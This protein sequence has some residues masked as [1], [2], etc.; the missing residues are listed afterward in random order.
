MTRHDV[1]S[2]VHEIFFGATDSS[3]VSGLLDKLEEALPHSDISDLI[4]HDFR[5]L[6]PEQVVDE[7][8]KRQAEHAA[9]SGKA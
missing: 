3:V 8:F 4:F 1:L 7:A 5:G 6:T 2:A 9:Q